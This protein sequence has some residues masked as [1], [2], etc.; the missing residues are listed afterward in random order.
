VQRSLK[1]VKYLPQFGWEPTVVTIEPE[2]AA[3]PDLDP[4][5]LRE[6][7]EQTR[8]VRTPGRDPY[9]AYA[10]LMGMKKDSAVGVGFLSRRRAGFRERAARWIR[11]NLFIPDARL[12]WN[13]FARAA[14]EK[15]LAA[16][17]F[18]AVFS[19][20]P[21]HSTHLVA[22]S[23]ARSS[24]LPWILDMRD[25]WPP[26]SFAHLLPAAA[27]ARRKDER[28]RGVTLSGATRILT[29]SQSLKDDL[30]KLTDTP[31]DVI[32][33]G[34]DEDD[35]RDVDPIRS[36]SFDIVYTG[37]LSAEQNPI[38]LWHALKQRRAGAGEAGV[39]VRLVGH[40]AN[41]VLAAIEQAG[42]RRRVDV[43]PYVEHREAIRHMSGAGL[44]LL[45]INRV[46]NPA[47]I[48]TGKLYE[49]LASTR[50][51]LC[52]SPVDGEAVRIV[53]ETRAGSAFRY[54]DAPGVMREIDRH[55]DA[56]KAG[57]PV[58]GAEPGLLDPYSRRNQAGQLAALLNRTIPDAQ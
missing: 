13:R 14:A 26:D 18:D 1:F 41:E 49:Y 17:S 29:V 38:A 40:V 4:G 21:P 24:G 48:V 56:W 11:A 34:F 54:E 9:A 43:V 7:P 53:G 58:E 45:C 3:Y 23:V 30:A 2:S 19:T 25:A 57:A 15:E 5:L 32:H 27:F 47:G 42:V 52:F 36:S 35:F 6:I 37:N 22:G 39:R 44:L 50:P 8:L 33:N 10:R 55:Y 28:L 12:G 16:A 20:G 31:V 46:P 51:V